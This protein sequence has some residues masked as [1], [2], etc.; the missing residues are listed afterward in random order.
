MKRYSIKIWITRCFLLILVLSALLSA[1]ANLYEAYSSNVRQRESTLKSCARNVANLLNHHW[2]LDSLIAPPDSEVRLE[3]QTLLRQLCIS[4]NLDY[5]YVYTVNPSVPSRYY[6]LVVSPDSDMEETV[7]DNLVM[8]EIPAESLLPEEEALLEGFGDLQRII[9]DNRYGTS[10]TWLA[11]YLDSDGNICA[12]IGMDYGMSRIVG[13][14]LGDFLTDMIPFFLSLLAGFL[15]LLFLVQ[16]RIVTPIGRLSASM[17]R[18]ALDSAG[19]PEPLHIAPYGEI[20]EMAMSFEKMTEDIQA[21]IRNIEALTRDQLEINVQL[22]VARRIQN[23]LVPEKEKLKGNGFSI[24]AIT[25]PAKAVGGDFYDCFLLGDGRVSAIMGD[26]SGKGI[27]AAICMSMMKTIIREKLLAGLTPADTLNAANDELCHRN[28]EGLF[29]TV[30]ASVLN[31]ETGELLYANAGH[32]YPVLLK[33]KPSLLIPDSGIALGMFENAGLQNHIL[34]IPAGKGILLYTDGVTEAVSP[35]KTF[36]GTDRLLEAL[37]NV[38]Y[39]ADAAEE[40]VLKVRRSVNAFCDGSEPFD[41]MAVLA[42]MVTRPA[43][44]SIPVT[45]DAFSEVKKTVFSLA[46]DTP[47]TRRAL[48]ACDEALANIVHYSGAAALS[49]ACQMEDDVLEITFADDGIPFDP[50]AVSRSDREFETLDSGGM[51]LNLIRQSVL[52]MAYIRKNGRNVF[53]LRFS[54]LPSA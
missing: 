1:G 18:F 13:R 54:L 36:F 9:L 14:I 53:T 33:E 51:G 27:S 39:E 32:T 12:F 6:Y 15:F 5:L 23:G 8:K 41:D 47:Q 30:F 29:V 38:L 49:F 46:G 17:K 35:R 42:L 25:H 24:S 21:Y 26:V 11:P 10:M 28:P 3:A 19:K 4:Y 22:D 40:A 48:L 50:T 45:L 43:E 52:S 44:Q 34:H 37:G 31:P 16:K 20:G 2:K 7:Q